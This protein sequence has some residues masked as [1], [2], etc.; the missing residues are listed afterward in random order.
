MP[1]GSKL[2]RPSTLSATR[3]SWADSSMFERY[4]SLHIFKEI[5]QRLTRE[6]QDREAEPRFT[7]T[8]A[9]GRGGYEG[10]PGRGG[11]FG[12]GFGGG[13]SAG[14]GAAGAGRQI[15]VS[16]VCSILPFSLF[17]NLWRTINIDF[18]T[19]ASIYSRMARSQGLVPSSW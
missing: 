18:Q 4:A 17:L 16:N 13:M 9:G 2:N 12:G 5:V 3:T 1:R 15:Y 7:G 11:G 19:L 8:P 6:W 14:G 10:P